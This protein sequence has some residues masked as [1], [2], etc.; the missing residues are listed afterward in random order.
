M[1][2][3]A[4]PIDRLRR[5]DGTLD[6]AAIRRILPYGDDFLFVDRVEHLD[7]ERVR[8]SFAIPVD[9]PYLRSHFVDLPVMP[10]VLIGEGLAQAGSLIVRY[11]LREP[12]ERHVLGLEIERARFLAPARPGETLIYNVEI[13][14][15]NRRAARLEGDVRVGTR[16]VCQAR[17]TVAIVERA[18]FRE[19]L[20]N[21]PIP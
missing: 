17:L 5:P 8:A 21:L 6:R 16:R 1:T 7:S 18:V 13:G 11:N 19:R 12:D 9:S 14:A 4:S 2:E 10:G 15:A 20:E 3:V